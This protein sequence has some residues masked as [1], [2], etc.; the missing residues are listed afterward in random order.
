MLFNS[1]KYQF[2]HFV[3]DTTNLKIHNL[4]QGI[5]HNSIFINRVDRTIHL[6]YLIGPNFGGVDICSCINVC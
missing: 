6:G 3:V 5:R 4:V 2:L 1:D